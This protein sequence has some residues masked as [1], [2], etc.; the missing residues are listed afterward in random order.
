MILY[1]L[2]NAILFVHVLSAKSNARRLPALNALFTVINLN[3]M[4]V[5]LRICARRMIALSVRPFVLL[6]TVVPLVLLLSLFVLLCVRRR[7]AIGNAKNPLLAL[8]LNANYN[9]INPLVK[10]R[11]LLLL[12]VVFAALVLLLLTS[13]LHSFKLMNM[14]H[15]IIWKLAMVCH[16][17]KLLLTLKHVN[18]KALKIVA[19]VHKPSLVALETLFSKLSTNFSI[20]FLA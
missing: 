15:K 5:A 7:N 20:Q 10:L 2:P 9:A 19:T 1:A 3:A 16:S 18:K 11:N 4:F 17:L 12:N 13:R 8:N 6:L 14:P